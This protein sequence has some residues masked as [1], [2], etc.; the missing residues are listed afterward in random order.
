MHSSIVI[1]NILLLFTAHLTRGAA[2]DNLVTFGASYTDNGR[3]NYYTANGGNAPPPG[4]LPP[5]TNVTASGGLSWGQLVQQET[6]TAY[7]DYAISGAVCSNA[8][9]PRSSRA[10][11]KPFPAVIEDQLPSFVA[12]TAF[13]TVYENRSADNTVYGV[14]I[15]TNDL[16]LNAFLTDSQIAGTNITTYIDC[17]WSIFDVLYSTGGRRFVLLNTAP[18]ELTPLYAALSNNGAGDNQYWKT[19]TTFNTTEYEQKMLEVS[20]F[21]PDHMRWEISTHPGFDNSTRSWSTGS[22]NMVVHSNSW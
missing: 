21:E 1:S 12:D 5:T 4:T 2:F 14:W 6:G 15:S 10:L 22:L 20:T 18:L 9:T 16:G 8:I 13:P 19:K 17:V 11:G 7:F 3:L